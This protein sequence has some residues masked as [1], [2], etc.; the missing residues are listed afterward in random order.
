MM[1]S[2][3]SVLVSLMCVFTWVFPG[4]SGDLVSGD[5][6]QVKEVISMGVPGNDVTR[7]RLDG[8]GL[9][10]RVYDL[11]GFPISPCIPAQFTFV[12]HPGG[13]QYD[14]PGEDYECAS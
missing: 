6:Y 7:V 1:T 11:A 12:E 8:P 2:V 4:S 3:T 13:V 5:V 9:Q 14:P 10:R